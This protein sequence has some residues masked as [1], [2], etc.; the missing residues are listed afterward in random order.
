MAVRIKICGITTADDALMAVQHGADAIGLNFYPRSPR[1]VTET[2]AAEILRVLPPF[3]EP[4]GLY[5]NE[6]LSHVQ[7]AAQRLG[8]RVVQIHGNHD[9]LPPAGP[10]RFISAFG[11]R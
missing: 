3:V 9:E 4:V 8:L 7:R 5:V 2:Q 10:V 6:S 1:Y 11:V